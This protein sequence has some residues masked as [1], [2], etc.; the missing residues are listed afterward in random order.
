MESILQ[1]VASGDGRRLRMMYGAYLSY[2]QLQEYASFMVNKGL[3]YKEGGT[4]LYKLTK[5]GEE[6]LRTG[7]QSEEVLSAAPVKT[8][9]G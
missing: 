7:E 2:E 1:V 6:F 3:V 5:K 9:P 4:E 8:H